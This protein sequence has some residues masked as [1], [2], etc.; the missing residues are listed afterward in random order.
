MDLEQSLVDYIMNANYKDFEIEKAISSKVSKE[1]MVEIGEE[2]DKEIIL[3]YAEHIR[4]NLQKLNEQLQISKKM[5]YENLTALFNKVEGLEREDPKLLSKRKKF[6]SQGLKN[7]PEIPTS[8]QASCFLYLEMMVNE[9]TEFKELFGTPLSQAKD[10]L[11]DK[12]AQAIKEQKELQLLKDLEKLSKDELVGTLNAL[13]GNKTFCQIHESTIELIDVYKLEKRGRV[14][15][16]CPEALRRGVG[17]RG[18][19]A[20]P[21]RHLR[22]ARPDRGSLCGR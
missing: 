12:L 17:A 16:G 20:H 10:K 18:V 22:H 1:R 7:L 5:V 8:E 2:L 11:V 9:D 13:W 15:F 19:L 14:R 21:S 4:N 6:I 3:E